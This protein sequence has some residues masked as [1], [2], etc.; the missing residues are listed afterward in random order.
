MLTNFEH[1]I[2]FMT[3]EDEMNT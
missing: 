3:L 2:D 1:I